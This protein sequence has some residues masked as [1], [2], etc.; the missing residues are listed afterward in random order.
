MDSAARSTPQSRA[1]H[2]TAFS[3]KTATLLSLRDI[4]PIRGISSR[5]ALCSGVITHHYNP[6]GY[7]HK[8]QIPNSKFV[9]PNSLKEYTK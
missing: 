6:S 4:S 3:A 7:G 5:G 8:F 2:V 9:I 1:M